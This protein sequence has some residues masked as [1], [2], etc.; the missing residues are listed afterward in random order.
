MRTIHLD[1]DNE[2]NEFIIE[3]LKEENKKLKA[4]INLLEDN[5]IYLNNLIDKAIE[6]IEKYSFKV[7]DMETPSFELEVVEI[8]ELLDI[9]R[10]NDNE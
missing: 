2:I 3:N 5:R 6:Y 8:N 1:N 10:G 9:L 7:S 4:E